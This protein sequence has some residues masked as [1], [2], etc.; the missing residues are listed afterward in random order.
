MLKVFG[1][2]PAGPLVENLFQV[3][4]PF[5]DFETFYILFALF[6]VII[7]LMFIIPRFTRFVIPLLFIHMITTAGPL[8]LL[9][10]ETWVAPFVPT[11]V[12]QYIIKK[13]TQFTERWIL[14][15]LNEK[16]RVSI[17]EPPR[18]PQSRRDSLEIGGVGITTPVKYDLVI[19]D[20]HGTITDHQLRTIRAYHHGAHVGL[21]IH[22]PKDF[23]H[24]A[25]TRPA[26]HDKKTE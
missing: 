14:K 5:I 11:L 13:L 4:I 16:P 18:T 12:G 1:L 3:T 22:L 20:F 7:G 17:S 21:G 19:M 9:P 23:Y 6:E 25:L 26:Q 24:A 15:M 10:I 2:S 8:V